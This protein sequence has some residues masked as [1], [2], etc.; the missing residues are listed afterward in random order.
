MPALAGPSELGAFVREYT[1]RNWWLYVAI[2]AG[3][4]ALDAPLL[5]L[6]FGADTRWAIAPG[7]IT[8]AIGVLGL[9]YSFVLALL[10]LRRKVDLHE[11]G[12]VSHSFSGTQSALWPQVQTVT[13]ARDWLLS[14]AEV[15]LELEGGKSLWVPPLLFDMDDLIARAEAAT[16]PL[17]Q[18][19]V[20]QALERGEV[21]SFGPHLSVSRYG[22]IH[23]PSIMSSE[24][25]RLDW[26]DI[27]SVVVARFQANPGA[28]GLA[29]A[30]TDVQVRVLGRDGSRW[31]VSTA[32]VANLSILLGLLEHRFGVEM[33]RL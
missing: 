5:Y 1:P 19:R 29:G 13:V 25:H 30:V 17:I 10:C 15:T 28:G 12:L 7:M 11:G 31:A 21:V 6:A 4:L 24:T 14:A 3:V 32:S 9:L 23:L 33:E 22:L 16:T 20:E 26:G 2:S 18:A 8:A 27:K